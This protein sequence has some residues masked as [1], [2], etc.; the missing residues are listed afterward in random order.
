M[1]Q[2]GVRNVVVEA[3]EGV[4]GDKELVCYVEGEGSLD[5]DLLRRKVEESL[6]SQMHPSEWVAVGSIPLTAHG[7]IDVGKLSQERRRVDSQGEIGARDE[8]ERQILEVWSEKLGRAGMGVRSNFFSW[9]G[10][11]IRA[12]RV[13]GELNKRYGFGLEVKDFFVHQTIESLG[14]YIRGGDRGASA[15]LQKAKQQ[16]DG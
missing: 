5:M 1:G 9:G 11:S 3:E 2:S 14:N 13:V 7:K 4:D 6:P 16:V 10:D 15:G 8:V 12:I